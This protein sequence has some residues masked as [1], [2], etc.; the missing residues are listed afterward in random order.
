ML[1][2]CLALGLLLVAS[3]A[4]ARKKPI[5]RVV[6]AAAPAGP[7]PP[8]SAMEID[9]DTGRVLYASSPDLRTYPAS[10]TK[11][12][13]LYLLFG[14]LDKGQIK[15]DQVL[16]ASAHA[17]SMPA[18]SLGLSPGDSL[19][20]EQAIHAI[21][22][23]SAN[24][25]A[26]VVAEALGGSEDAF[27][28]TMTRQARLLGMKDTVFR[29][30]SGLPDLEQKTTARD[31]ATLSRALI[32]RFPAYYHYFAE[33]SFTY[34]GRVYVGHNH[35]LK[36]YEGADGLKTGYIRA[37][38]FNLASSAV[39]NGHRVIAVI[40]GGRSPGSRDNEMM[41]LLDRGFAALGPTPGET[42]NLLLARNNPPAQAAT[43]VAIVMPTPTAKLMLPIQVPIIAPAALANENPIGA[44]V[45]G[46]VQRPAAAPAAKP[47][48]VIALGTM[49]PPAATS[50]PTV[51]AAAPIAPAAPATAA[52]V[53]V[54]ALGEALIAPAKAAPV[55][56]AGSA[57]DKPAKPTPPAASEKAILVAS[58]E[59]VPPPSPPAAKPPL[60]LIARPAGD[61]PAKPA[62]PAASAKAN[63]VLVGSA[64]PVPPPTLLPSA[65]KP[66]NLATPLAKPSAPPAAKQTAAKPTAT[67]PRAGAAHI[68]LAA[69][70]S[71]DTVVVASGRYAI[72]VGAYGKF[73]PARQAAEQATRQVPT[74][75][76]GARIA[77][78]EKP[79]ESGKIYR[80]R[81]G[82]LTE[83][84]ADAA[85][86]QLKARGTS[87]MVVKPGLAMAMSTAP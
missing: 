11:L 26:S 25:V 86:R 12:M 5:H 80:S 8:S 40:L 36:R 1:F 22:V 15:L 41:T 49:T 37:A 3:P 2:G 55:V 61:K 75:L 45:A 44:G 63:P 64:E 73:A 13:T 77:I 9:A 34:G 18:T 19:T 47:A 43:T 14:A 82:G 48:P 16:S 65:A 27:A 10:L 74:L 76:R 68:T 50:A 54:L 87:C 79:G 81:I 23:R 69:I 84:G 32:Q 52:A 42:P 17:A 78:D 38:G 60:V 31:M 85:C 70:D 33:D 21:I 51:A 62:Q 28:E 29:N 53:P 71:G 7:L 30:A 20:V 58:A 57:A 56:V 4:E 35:L 72:Q 24:D 59:P 46:P 39:R 66:V 6:H 83:A 67:K